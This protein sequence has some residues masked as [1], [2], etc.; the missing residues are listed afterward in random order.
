MA[1]FDGKL[2]QTLMGNRGKENPIKPKS[3]I[4]VHSNQIYASFSSIDTFNEITQK[5]Q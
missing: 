1:N 4:A 5:I 2:L 3:P